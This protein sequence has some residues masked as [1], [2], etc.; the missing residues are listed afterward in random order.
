MA[1]VSPV[2]TTSGSGP[3]ASV[4]TTASILAARAVSAASVWRP[5]A[6]R[7]SVMAQAASRCFAAAPTMVRRGPSAISRKAA[8]TT[9]WRWL[10]WSAVVCTYTP[11]VFVAKIQ[12]SSGASSIAT[13]LLTAM[14]SQGSSGW[15]PPRRRTPPVTAA[16]SAITSV[17]RPAVGLS[18]PVT[19]PEHQARSL[20]AAF[21]ATR[22]AAWRH[23]PGSPGMQVTLAVAG[24]G[25]PVSPLLTLVVPVLSLLRPFLF[26]RRVPKPHDMAPALRVRE[27]KVA[28]GLHEPPVQVLLAL[29][30]APAMLIRNYPPGTLSAHRDSL[31]VR[32][33]RKIG[34]HLQRELLQWRRGRLANNARSLFRQRRGKPGSLKQRG[35]FKGGLHVHLSHVFAYD[36][37]KQLLRPH[38]NLRSGPGSTGL[39]GVSTA[40]LLAVPHQRMHCSKESLLQVRACQ[41]DRYRTARLWS[42]Q[43]WP[44]WLERNEIYMEVFTR[45]QLILC[46]LCWL[47]SSHSLDAKEHPGS[48]G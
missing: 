6:A 11:A 2:P 38:Q 48:T 12:R 39:R 7:S 34:E 16:P 4:T 33:T 43:A 32:C 29:A 23:A 21:A 35:T 3:P 10:P 19:W 36:F 13:V 18:V 45:W 22:G 41:E 14:A 47:R 1:G 20:R 25:L 26:S 46:T 40:S 17:A 15:W 44:T 37:W 27:N 9:P 24:M 8:R 31:V 28:R 30:H 5:A 42:L